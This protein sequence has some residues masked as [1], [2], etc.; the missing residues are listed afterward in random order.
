MCSTGSTCRSWL[1]MHIYYR[2]Y[3][4]YRQY[5]VSSTYKQYMRYTQNMDS[6]AYIFRAAGSI[7][8]QVQTGSTDSTYNSGSAG[9]IGS[10]G[11]TYNSGSAGNLSASTSS[12]RCAA[13]CHP[14]CH[15]ASFTSNMYRQCKLQMPPPP[16]PPP[17]PPTPRCCGCVPHPRSSL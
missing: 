12:Y 2:Q 9:S 13:A 8:L 1:L 11:S 10:I 3:R 4:Q 15:M 7:W 17:T 5:M 6:H 16:P 14:W